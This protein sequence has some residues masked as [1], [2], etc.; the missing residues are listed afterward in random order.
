MRVG[1]EADPNAASPAAS[2]NVVDDVVVEREMMVLGPL[3][4]DLARGGVHAGAD[5]RP[6]SSM[7]RRV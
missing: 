6:C 3:V 2:R 4:V 5:D 7:M 1:D